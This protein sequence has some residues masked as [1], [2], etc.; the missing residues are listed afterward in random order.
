MTI[1]LQREG[2]N[3]K[4]TR[5]P[6]PTNLYTVFVLLLNLAALS[7]VFWDA[8]GVVVLMLTLMYTAHLRLL[9][10]QRSEQR[11]TNELLEELLESQSPLPRLE[12]E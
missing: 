5:H 12:L 1:P 3:V 8:K 4:F 11:R 9:L 6:V 2:L 7:L 10:T